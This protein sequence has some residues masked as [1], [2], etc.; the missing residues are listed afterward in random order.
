MVD[1][2]LNVAMMIS[3][4]CWLVG[5]SPMIGR[6][7]D[8]LAV[9]VRPHGNYVCICDRLTCIYKHKRVID[10]GVVRHSSATRRGQPIA[11]ADISD[12]KRMNILLAFTHLLTSGGADNELHIGKGASLYVPDNPA[13]LAVLH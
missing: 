3:P 7:D 4:L 11:Q 1:S 6:F 8:R 9:I 12:S 2:M 10:V 13:C 5:K